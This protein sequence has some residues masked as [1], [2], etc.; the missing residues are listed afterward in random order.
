M[1][2]YFSSEYPSA[3]KLNGAFLGLV[4]KS[5]KGCNININEDVYVE[6]CGADGKEKTL[7]FILNENFFNNIPPN[8]IVTDL[9]GGYLLHATK[10][11]LEEDFSVL[12]QEKYADLIA[13]VFLDKGYKLSIETPTDFYAEQLKFSFNSVNFNRFNINGFSFFACELVGKESLLLVFKVNEKIEKVF[14]RQVKSASFENGFTTITEIKDIA[15]HVITTCWGFNGESL[16]EKE[17]KIEV[18]PN[19]MVENLKEEIIPYAFLEAL[20]AKDNLA[21]Y[22]TEN[23][24]QKKQLLTG[25][26][27]DFIGIMP[28][29]PFRNQKEVGLIYRTKENFYSVYYCTFTLVNRKIDNIKKEG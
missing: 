28:P 14:C 12:A 11:Y 16:V 22:L 5:T 17:T 26:L 10:S 15:K 3:V 21:P 6:F 25:Y 27:G 4:G 13:T 9:N 19:F 8:L 1:Y 7:S 2:I 29:P 23:M 18:S 20:L 24:L